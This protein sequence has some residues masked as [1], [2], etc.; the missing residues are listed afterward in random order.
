MCNSVKRWAKPVVPVYFNLDPANPDHATK[1]CDLVDDEKW[2]SLNLANNEEIFKNKIIH[3]VIKI[4]CFR[5]SHSL[6]M[7]NHACFIP[8]VPLET[9]AYACAIICHLIGSYRF[10]DEKL[11]D[12]NSTGNANNFHQYLKMLKEIRDH[13]PMALMNI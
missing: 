3:D 5:S 12:L 6:G 9:I 2:L 7:K 13:N 10:D 1:A 11:S 4:S 8:L